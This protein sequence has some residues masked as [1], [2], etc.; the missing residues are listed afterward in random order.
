MQACLTPAVP[1]TL[2]A[3]VSVLR[4]RGVRIR[5]VV[6]DGF[7]QDAAQD[8]GA[9]GLRMDRDGGLRLVAASLIPLLQSRADGRAVVVRLVD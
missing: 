4:L 7:A 5:V 8:S 9:V 1:P 3:L 6:G 2:P